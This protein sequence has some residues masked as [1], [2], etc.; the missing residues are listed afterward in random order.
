MHAGFGGGVGVD[1]R[2][3]VYAR[4]PGRG[5]FVFGILEVGDLVWRLLV[6]GQHFGLCTHGTSMGILVSSCAAHVWCLRT[7]SRQSTTGTRAASLRRADP[8]RDGCCRFAFVAEGFHR[9]ESAQL[10]EP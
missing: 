3:V 7:S 8:G 6:G 10:G 4:T 1:S 5:N 9:L 2:F